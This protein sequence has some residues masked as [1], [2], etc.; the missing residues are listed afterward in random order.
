MHE[1]QF[2]LC[3]F[4]PVTLDTC[5]CVGYILSLFKHLIWSDILKAWLFRLVNLIS[6]GYIYI[7]IIIIIV[8]FRNYTTP[9]IEKLINRCDGWEDLRKFD[10]IK[11]PWLNSIKPTREIVEG[12]FKKLQYSGLNVKVK[13][14]SKS[15]LKTSGFYQ[16]RWPER[17]AW[18]LVQHPT[19]FL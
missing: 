5:T 15:Q 4:Y 19:C 3:S 7:Y 6:Y 16:M 8:V 9:E 11:Q 1:T 13:F 17:I 2:H 10:E 18:Q 12:R 14:L